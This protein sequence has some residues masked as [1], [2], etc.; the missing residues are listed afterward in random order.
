MEQLDLTHLLNRKEEEKKLMNMLKNF[1]KNKKELIHSRGMYIY[2]AP[3]SG[4]S[5]FV[6]NILKKMNYDIVLYDAGDIRNKSVIDNITKHKISDNSVLA[7]FKKETKR[8]VIIMDE[9]DGMNSGDKGG[10]NTLIKLIR[11]KK[12]KKQKTEDVT[13]VPIICI[14][15]YHVDKK[16]KELIKVCETIELKK[17]TKEQL[18][19]IINLIL[20]NLEDELKKN[21]IEFSQCDLRKIHSAYFIYKNQES[22][23]KKK[24]IKNMFQVKNHNE[25]TKVI[26]KKLLNKKYNLKDHQNVINDTD[27]TSIGLLFHE[28]IIE[29]FK[30]FKHEDSINLY[31]KVLDNVCFSDYIDR[32]TFQKQIWVFNE[33]S[34]LV[35]TMY[36]NKILFEYKNKVNNKQKFNP[37]EVRFTKVLTKYSTEYN[38]MV[39]LQDLCKQLNM[40]KPDMFL[41][42]L[43][44]RS[45]MSIEDII[46]LFNNENYDINKLDVNRIFR[47]LDFGKEVL[48]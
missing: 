26:V 10:I 9:I 22:L 41:F 33:M 44:L 32:I 30:Y 39:F 48:I 37:P 46:N 16:I 3:G 15:N 7:M 13:M 21:I 17:P 24:M 25:D 45:K 40:D 18:D 29:T 34:S 36:N 23:F 4:K 8:I 6:K 27:R 5:T 19:N 1:E 42:F 14:G 43:D 2:G 47:F 28:N 20:P 11:P 35:K 31:L 38:N 12:T